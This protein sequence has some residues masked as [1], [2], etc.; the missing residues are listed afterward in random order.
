MNKENQLD[1]VSAYTLHSYADK[2]SNNPKRAVNVNVAREKLKSDSDSKVVHTDRITELKHELKASIKPEHH[3]KYDID[4]V[5]SVMDANKIHNMAAANEHLRDYGEYDRY[6]E[7]VEI[8]EAHPNKNYNMFS[9]IRLKDMIKSEIEP[10]YHDQYP[11]DKIKSFT[12]KHKI[13]SKAKEAGHLSSDNSKMNENLSD[14]T[15]ALVS[16]IVD[17]DTIS[18][19]DN[20]A[21]AIK[22]KLAPAIEELKKNQAASMFK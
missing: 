8:N 19:M 17:N 22:D 7:S 20:F 18:I 10:E 14:S 5:K 11:I 1:E 9:V 13:Y 15:K 6:D 21:W 4:R 3:E 16:S 2:A 12:D